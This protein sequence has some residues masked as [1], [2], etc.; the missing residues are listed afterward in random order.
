MRGPL[1]ENALGPAEL[2]REREPDGLALRFGLPYARSKS[3]DDDCGSLSV[4]LHRS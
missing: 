3:I 1:G 4:V 2:V